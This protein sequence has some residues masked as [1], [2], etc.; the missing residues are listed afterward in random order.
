MLEHKI[1]HEL[2]DTC[3]DACDISKQFHTR[4]VSVYDVET[5]NVGFDITQYYIYHREKYQKPILT[6]VATYWVLAFYQGF[7]AFAIPCFAYST[8]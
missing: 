8:T 1:F 7:V 5:I 3:S 4:P 6:R 2:A